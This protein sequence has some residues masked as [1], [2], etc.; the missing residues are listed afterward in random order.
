MLINYRIKSGMISAHDIANVH[1]V[2]KYLII[3]NYYVS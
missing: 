2:V 1:D 3:E